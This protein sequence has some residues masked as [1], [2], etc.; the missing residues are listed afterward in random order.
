MEAKIKSLEKLLEEVLPGVDLKNQLPRTLD[1][2]RTIVKATR[3]ELGPSPL[4]DQQAYDPLLEEDE[5][6]EGPPEDPDLSVLPGRFV[7]PH[8]ALSLTDGSASKKELYGA[9]KDPMTHL[10][11]DNSRSLVERLLEREHLRKRR[12]DT[13]FP[14]PDLAASLIEL[15]FRHV[16]RWDPIIHKP[17]FIQLYS[18]DAATTDPSFR[19]LCY[20]VFATASRFS[21]DPRVLSDG[22]FGQVTKQGAGAL[23][24]AASYLCASAPSVPW[25]LFDLQY[26]A[27]MSRFL[28]ASSSPTTVWQMT[29]CWI[30]TAQD[31]G[32]HREKTPQWTRSIMHDQLRKRAFWF[33]VKVDRQASLALG[34]N[35]N[36]R[37]SQIDLGEQCL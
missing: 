28:L 27:V 21:N 16:H 34:R 31:V 7:G 20:A 18:T 6:D 11:E 8:S 5:A 26:A 25:N 36:I 19:A 3:R 24:A 14:P 37:E 33:M 2:A 13:A 32:S 12:L 1:Q 15:Y 29:G 10:D 9:V 17:T 22:Q 30:R 23:Y 4:S 35:T